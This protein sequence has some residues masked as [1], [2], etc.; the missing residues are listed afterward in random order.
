MD[1]MAGTATALVLWTAHVPAGETL[2]L[3][4]AAI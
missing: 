3:E 2:F 4:A 1:R